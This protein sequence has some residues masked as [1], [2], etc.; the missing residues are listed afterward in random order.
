MSPAL[1]MDEKHA[2]LGMDMIE[3]AI[4]KVE[5]QFGYG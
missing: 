4:A 5:Q 2:A 1:I 3:E